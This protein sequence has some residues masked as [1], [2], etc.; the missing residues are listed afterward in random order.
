M[1]STGC[2]RGPGFPHLYAEPQI[3]VP[4]HPAGITVC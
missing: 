2:V 1:L 3:T 4:V